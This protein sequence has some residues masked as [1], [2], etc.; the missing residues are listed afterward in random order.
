MTVCIQHIPKTDM[1]EMKLIIEKFM[2]LWFHTGKAWKHILPQQTSSVDELC[3]FD[4]N[5]LKRPMAHDFKGKDHKNNN[6]NWLRYD[7][8]LCFAHRNYLFIHLLIFFQEQ[9]LF[10]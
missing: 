9:S 2:K 1:I 8:D 4:L 6:S 3:R 10:L 5:E 7:E